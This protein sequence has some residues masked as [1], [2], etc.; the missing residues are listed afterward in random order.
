MNNIFSR[1]EAL[2]S[3]AFGSG[4]IGFGNIMNLSTLNF[5]ENSAGSS[6]GGRINQSV[7]RWC[8]QDIPLD[9]FAVTCKEIGIKAIDLLK[10]SEW[11]IVQKH[12]LEIAMG[13]DDFAIIE[14]GFNDPGNHEKLQKS[15]KEF[16]DKASE[17]GVRN[18]ICFSGNR[19]GMD[20]ET[21][22]ENCA[23]G[24]RPL[25]DHAAERNVNLVMEL[26]NSKVNH[27]DYMCDHTAWGVALAEKLGMDNFKL[28]Y[29]IY[30]MQVMEGDV[31]ATI[32]K[33]HRY[34]SHYHTAG[35]PGRNEIDETQELYYPAIMKAIAETGFKGYVA[36]EFVPLSQDKLGAL[37]EAVS[38]CDV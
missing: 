38:I 34:I 7:C 15:Y 35:V 29:D 14:H 25:L 30:H 28:L 19:R 9:E 27:P 37:K 22:L 13:T 18:I 23:V 31:I 24:L 21:G 12:G 20:D 10:P 6:F 33:Y 26:L 1:R 17:A 3:M 5:F 8:F 36:Q 2:K 4:V 32:R 11:E 16:I